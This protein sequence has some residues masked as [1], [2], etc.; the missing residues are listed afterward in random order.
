MAELLALLS[1]RILSRHLLSLIYLFTTETLLGYFLLPSGSIIIES[2][3]H[4]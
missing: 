4:Y 1:T 3:D 2:Y